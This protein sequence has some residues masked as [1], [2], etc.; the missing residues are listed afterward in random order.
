MP[1]SEIEGQERAVRL[2]RRAL[3]K[4]ELHHAYLV[5]GPEGVGKELLSRLVA[6][7]ANCESP[8]TERPCGA[9]VACTQIARG[10]FP[11]V[12]WVRPQSELVAK[13]LVNKGDLET[14]PSRE[15]RVDEVRQLARRLAFAL[16][17]GR[18][19]VAIVSPAE[20]LNERAQ[21][22]LLKTLE[23]PP[24]Q[25]TFLLVTSAP[26]QLLATVR[27]RCARL[28][29]GPLADEVV[30]RKLLKQGVPPQEAKA[31]AVASLGSLAKALTFTAEALGERNALR[32]Q[33][34]AAL[35][36]PDERLAL[37]LAEEHAERD[38][39]LA[40]CDL[41]AAELHDEL[42]AY[43][44]G[45]HEGTQPLEALRALDHLKV[46]REGLLQ[47]GN[48]RLQLERLLLGLR[49]LRGE[50]APRG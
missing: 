17:R 13:G 43:G 37:D 34:R 3:A 24:P 20:T 49:E 7:A 8:E 44:D 5:V 32:D 48:P 38:P 28:P 4:G 22:A 15:I 39:A 18:R 41:W 30:E 45:A 31:R 47:N 35:R 6:Q 50:G 16:V 10:V 2:V 1:W 9:C 12:F 26:D 11:D 40:I 23:E 42:V 36:E 46:V 25:T 19:K 14:A 33:V 21:N 29:L 27:S